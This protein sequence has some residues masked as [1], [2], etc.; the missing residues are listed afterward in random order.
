MIFKTHILGIPCYCRVL[1]YVP[2]T[3]TRVYGPAMEDA[4]PPEEGEFEYMILDRTRHPA[5][6]LE[7]LLT[8]ELHNELKE[9]TH[10]LWMAESD[11]YSQP[12]YTE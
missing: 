5:P 10:I 11:Q 2:D 1:K 3:P 12:D 4:D 7:K 6:W 9:D 8:V